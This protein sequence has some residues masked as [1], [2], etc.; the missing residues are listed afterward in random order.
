MIVDGHTLI[1]A[2]EVRAEFVWTTVNSYDGGS[3]R[4]FNESRF[5]GGHEDDFL[6]LGT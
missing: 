1:F 5:H 3:T 2:G 4:A 6:P